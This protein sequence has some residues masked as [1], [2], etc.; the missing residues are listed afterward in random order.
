MAKNIE[1]VFNGKTG[2][3]VVHYSGVPTHAE[4]HAITDKLIRELRKQGFDVDTDHFHDA[5]RIPDVEE[6]AE[7]VKAPERVRGA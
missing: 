7:I 5:P 2:D 4:E 3:F 6:D 1:I